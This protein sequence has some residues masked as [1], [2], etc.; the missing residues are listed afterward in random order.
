MRKLLVL[1]FIFQAIILVA[2]EPGELKMLDYSRPKEYVIADI[3]VTGVKY[4]NPTHLVSIS[5][6]YKG[7]KITIPGSD[8]S[9]AIKKYWK[10]G[11]FADVQVIIEK[12]EGS[13]VYLEI[14]LIEQPRMN[15]LVI[16]G[17]NKS[18]QDDIKEKIGV[19]RGTQITD[20]VVNNSITIIKKHFVEKGF[21]NT[22]VEITQK[23]DTAGANR[24]NLYIDIKKNERVKIEEIIFVGNQVFPEKQL[25]RSMKKTKQRDLNIFKGS[26]YIEDDYIEDKI[27]LIDLYNENGY[28]DA[29]ILS[30]ELYPIN[31]KRIGLKLTLYEGNKYF[32]RSINWVGNTKYPTTYLNR[33]LGIHE[34]ELYDKKL[35]ENRLNMDE[36]AVSTLYMD[37]GYLFFQVT[38]IEASVEEDSVDL[39]LRIYE[40]DPATINKIIILGNT[41]TNEHVVRRELYT[42]PGELFSKTDLMRSYREIANLGHFNAENIGVDPIPNQAD[43]TVDIRYTLE[44]RANDQ[45]ELSGGWGGTYGFVGS[46]GVKFTNLSVGRIFDKEAWRPVPTGDGQ[47]LSLRAQSNFSYQAFNISFMEPW[48]GGKK[49]NSFTVSTN[50]TIYRQP[51]SLTDKTFLGTFKTVGAAIGFG[52]R[53]SWPDDYFSVYSELSYN[54]YILDNYNRFPLPNGGYNLVSLKGVVSRS[55]QDQPI[56]PRKGSVISLSLQVTPPYSLING[57]DYS[58]LDNYEKYR[59]VEFHK[60]TFNAAWYTQLI[61]DLVLALKS[62]FGALGFYN[63][64]IGYP[65]FE[66]FD[67]GGSG[68]SGYSLAGT[69]IIPL[70]GYADGS[71]TPPKTY[72]IKDSNGNDIPRTEGNGNVYTRYYSELRYPISL[73][74]SATLYGLVFL[75]GGNVW[76]EWDKFNPFSI[77]RSAGVGIRAFLPMFGLLGFD[78]GWGFDPLLDEATGRKIG[79]EKG[80]FHFIIGQQ[81]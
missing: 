55:S 46:V 80:E 40:G 33:V 65:I 78:Y 57:V 41:K 74:P 59:N 79:G 42:R 18:E 51:K 21:F 76:S 25:R 22:D 1:F 67:M 19:R 32:I 14:R 27:K 34:K 37:N 45:L 12:I 38:P 11:L 10:H 48:F 7:K 28:R 53:L 6:L 69:D 31:E 5:G 62:E 81:L 36:D 63:N 30:E 15:N 26:K 20:N 68:L 23:E 17:I 64:D 43:G 71:L 77:K 72:L 52:K 75:E 16:T 39:E 4:L 54:R 58:T 24:I 29:K 3:N 8:I 70:R 9:D 50:Y 60:W 49:P 66:K 44:E 2:Q 61:G 35:L 73:N 47:T 13:N 56:Y